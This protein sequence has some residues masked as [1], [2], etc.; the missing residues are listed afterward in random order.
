MRNTTSILPDDRLPVE[1]V[2]YY[3]DEK[4]GPKPPDN[5]AF[6]SHFSLIF[7]SL[8]AVEHRASKQNEK[9]LFKKKILHWF[10]FI[11]KYIFFLI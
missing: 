1:A 3:F 8:L 10:L 11:M 9:V 7:I 4:A 5:F 6:A 2:R